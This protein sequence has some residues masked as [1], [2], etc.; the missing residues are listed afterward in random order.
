[1]TSQW[2]FDGNR[3]VS[4]WTNISREA[5]QFSQ[6]LNASDANG[7]YLVPLPDF[8][9]HSPFGGTTWFTPHLNWSNGAADL[10]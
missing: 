6:Q 8:A 1:M 9:S 5:G 10:N 7:S 2:S 4:R 3:I